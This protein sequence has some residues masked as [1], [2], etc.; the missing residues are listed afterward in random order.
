LPGLRGLLKVGSLG[1]SLSV[2][3]P[4]MILQK[5]IGLGRV[6]LFMHL[7]PNFQ[8]GLWAA[9][10][11]LFE[12]ITPVLTLGS[13]HGMVRYVSFYE[14]RGRLQAFYRRMR[15]GVLATCLLLAAAAFAASDLIRQLA[16]ASR[17]GSSGASYDQQMLIC[18]A[19]LGNALLMALYLNMLGFMY[20]MRVY[21]LIST[22]EVCFSVLFTVL[23]IA[24]LAAC[25]TGLAV[26]VA[27][28]AALAVTLVVGMVLLHLGI[29]RLGVTEVPQLIA[30]ET[31]QAVV[32]EPAAEIDEVTTAV[33]VPAMPAPAIEP[34]ALKDILS[35]VL[36]FGLVALF[37]NLLWNAVGYLSYRL[38]SWQY[39]QGAGG[40]YYAL[41]RL[42]QPVMFLA[43]A[44]WMVLFTHVAS[45]WEKKQRNRA[46]FTLETAYKAISMTMMTLTIAVYITSP[47][48]IKIVPTEYRQGLSLVGG[49]LMFFQVLT[50]L[51]LMQI[52]VKLHERPIVIA[53]AA[54]AG[55]AVSLIL[56][57]SWMGRYEYGPE[58]IA[59][60][61]G[62]GMYLGAGAVTGLYF[63]AFR[64][65][66]HPS[67]YFVLAAPG[68]LFLAAWVG[69]WGVAAIWATVLA[70]A[71]LTDWLFSEAQKKLLLSYVRRLGGLRK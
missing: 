68:L 53:V 2:Y 54:V 59:R 63:L 36:S 27:H 18:W 13:N 29:Q 16:I 15:W 49:L 52:L 11:Y 37:S 35:R 38:A 48:W 44:S 51:A 24:V 56:A 66:L 20:G 70:A 39:G 3:V 26:L 19:A 60:A 62:L 6:L 17:Q 69:I 14:A 21:R 45:L 55:G 8:Y 28:G 5:A 9:G 47:V 33:E 23:G 67:T 65:R 46:M 41:M 50:N 71:A 10:A 30:A 4:A 61:F 34:G 42:G 43:N 40:V 58:G 22:V 1:E 25:P 12:L 31:H 32:L 64:L 7:V 57:M